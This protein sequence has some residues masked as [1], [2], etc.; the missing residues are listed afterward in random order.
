[1]S[2]RLT[3]IDAQTPASGGSGTRWYG[4]SL[5]KPVKAQRCISSVTQHSRTSAQKACL[6]SRFKAKSRPQD[7]RTLARYA[8]PGIEAVA[9]SPR[10]SIEDLASGR[11]YEL[12]HV[13]RSA[14]LVQ[15]R[16]LRL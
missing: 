6:R 4:S 7:P 8:K 13:G 15:R 11:D 16:S 5:A 3:V 1:M 2:C 10:N 12:A 9:A 14:A